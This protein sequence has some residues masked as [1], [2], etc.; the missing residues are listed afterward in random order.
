[1]ASLSAGRA[2]E[3]W[4]PARQQGHDLAP[5]SLRQHRRRDVPRSEVGIGPGREQ[6]PAR[7]RTVLRPAPRSREDSGTGL[8][9]SRTAMRGAPSGCSVPRARWG[10]RRLRAGPR[11]RPHGRRSRPGSAACCPPDPRPRHRLR[12]R[13][14]PPA[15]QR[16]RS[17][18]R[19]AARTY[20]PLSASAGTPFGKQLPHPGGIALLRRRDQPT[21]RAVVRRVG[22]SRVR[23]RCAPAGCSRRRAHHDGGWPGRGA[24]GV[25]RRVRDQ[26]F[27]PAGGRGRHPSRAEWPRTT[28]TTSRIASAVTNTVRGRRGS[29]SAGARLRTG[30]FPGVEPPDLTPDTLREHDRRR[31]IARA[32]VRIR[33]GLDQHPRRPETAPLPS[34]RTSEIDARGSSS[35]RS[36]SPSAASGCLVPRRRSGQRRPTP[37]TLPPPRCQKTRRGSAPCCR[38]CPIASRCARAVTRTWST[39]TAGAVGRPVDGEGFHRSRSQRPPLRPAA[40]ARVQHRPHPPPPRAAPPDCRPPAHGLPDAQEGAPP[41]QARRRAPPG[42]SPLWRWRPRANSAGPLSP[43]R[44]R[45]KVKE[46]SPTGG[47]QGLPRMPR[48]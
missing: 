17:R 34:A 15:R 35:S 7:R 33:P 9:T 1:M 8:P 3:P 47:R 22:G 41:V 45:W 29:S 12:R 31:V 16:S 19:G 4:S 24:R 18:R 28:T 23:P 26:A 42:T 13:T 10:Q 32:E 36:G 11:Q 30:R 25:V 14:A 39:G 5:D 38:T 27:G 20:P 40:P 46:S 44:D 48:R 37:G 21:R 43:R 2:P 6:R